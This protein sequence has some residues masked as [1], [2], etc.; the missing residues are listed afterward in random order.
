MKNICILILL[1]ILIS[2]NAISQPVIEWK[3]IIGGSGEDVGSTILKADDGGYIVVGYTRSDDGDIVSTHGLSDIIL[4]K[5]N[6]NGQRE[7]VKTYGGS[8]YEFGY[9]INKTQDG[10]YIIAGATSSDDG[11]TKSTLPKDESNVW[12][13]KINKKGDIENEKT[14]GGSQIDAAL[15]VQQTKDGGYIFCGWTDSNDGDVSGY[16]AMQDLWVAKINS[17]FVIEWQR[18]MGGNWPDLARSVLQTSDGGYIIIGETQSNEG[19][20]HGNHEKYGMTDMWVIK[21]DKDGK[22]VWNQVLGDVFEDWGGS[23]VE[24]SDSGFVVAGTAQFWYNTEI[25]GHG[26]DDFWILK[27]NKLGIIEWQKVYGGYD[28]DYPMDILH[29]KDGGFLVAGASRSNDGDVTGHHDSDNYDCWLI[30]ISEIGD[31][32]WQKSIYQ[33]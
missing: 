14:F 28:H 33:D 13:I 2:I 22:T 32:E 19:D 27:I 24:T 16:H 12:L 30:K 1:V 7:W 20:V 26:G 25:H 8:S 31:I 10:G 4:I 23:V 3:S 18:T 6:A 11:D 17:E 5:L 15:S 21:L 29:V 9:C